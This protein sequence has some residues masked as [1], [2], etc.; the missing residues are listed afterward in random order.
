[1]LTSLFQPITLSWAPLL[2]V[3]LFSGNAITLS[4]LVH[5]G[6]RSNPAQ[7]SSNLVLPSNALGCREGIQPV[8]EQVPAS[9]IQGRH[10][11]PSAPAGRV[12]GIQHLDIPVRAWP[13][14]WS[15]LFGGQG[16][17]CFA[18]V[19]LQVAGT[20]LAE[21][22]GLEKSLNSSRKAVQGRRGERLLKQFLLIEHDP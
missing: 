20:C 4:S 9:P 3:P 19:V 16:W 2:V 5:Q 1:M 21:F 18:Q 14:S 15:H 17:I 12:A 7:I 10:Q 13:A 6:G 22:I 11:H 8:R